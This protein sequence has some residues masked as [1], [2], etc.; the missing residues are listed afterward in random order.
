MALKFVFAIKTEEIWEEETTV[1]YI[2]EKQ[3]WETNGY[4]Q[5]SYEVY[6]E[7]EDEYMISNEMEEFYENFLEEHNITELQESTFEAPN[8]SEEELRILLLN[9]G[10]F[11]YDESFQSFIDR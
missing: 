11:T 5:D 7:E 2:T 4:L 1:L 3:Y 8:F 6:N 10:Y 9:S